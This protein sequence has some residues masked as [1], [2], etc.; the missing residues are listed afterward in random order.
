[1][2][3]LKRSKLPRF[4]NQYLS[5]I[6]GSFLNGDKLSYILPSL[7]Q[8]LIYLSTLSIDLNHRNNLNLSILNV[9]N[10][11]KINSYFLSS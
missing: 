6:V 4:Q 3:L 10:L 1:M 5:G 11:N 9:L 8:K 2:I 7:L